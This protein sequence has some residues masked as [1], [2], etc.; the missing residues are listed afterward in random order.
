MNTILQNLQRRSELGK[1]A[2]IVVDAQN[3]FLHPSGLMAK[4]GQIRLDE[5]AVELFLRN[6][7]AV[8]QEARVQKLPV[9]YAVTVLRPDHA[10]SALCPVWRERGLGPEN[11]FLVEGSWGAQIVDG[12]AP[13]PGDHVIVKK[14]HGAF[15]GTNLDRTLSN[16]GVIQCLIVGAGGLLG[17]ADDTARQ[18]APLGYEATLVSDATYP[19]DE[20]QLTTLDHKAQV[21]STREAVNLLGSQADWQ[22]R[23]GRGA[24][25]NFALLVVDLQNDSIHPKGANAL[26][27]GSK[28]TAAEFEMVVRNNRS[29][30]KAMRE[31]NYP[32]IH[33]LPEYRPDEIDFCGSSLYYRTRSSEMPPG[34]KHRQGSWG[35]E[36]VEGVE[37]AEGD[38]VLVKKTN[39]AFSFTC[40]H[41]LLRNL[42]VGRCIVTGGSIKGCVS[43][44]LRDGIVLGYEMIP[45]SDAT[46][47]PNS[48]Y[49]RILAD[50]MRILSTDEALS[51]LDS[52]RAN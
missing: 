3:D 45:V 44:T 26:Y 4:K 15:A 43:D 31:R 7:R 25:A 49:L 38:L 20:Y 21:K 10:D 12:L 39:S 17:G 22:A 32:V 2:V 46:Y 23:A 37:P 13:E 29:L 8:I 52:E 36:F 33:T 24:G 14:G 34:T 5:S 6:C 11:G 47:K 35:N 40:L 16:L 1:A 41:R 27:G 30:M 48:P 42:D 9:F 28:L 18:S 19:V 51:L 50:R